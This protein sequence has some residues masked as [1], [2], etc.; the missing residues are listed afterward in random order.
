VD[1]GGGPVL[2][3]VGS[4]NATTREQL[5]RLGGVP[6]VAM[7]LAVEDVSAD[8]I[9]ALITHG[10][11]V[12]HPAAGEGDPQTIVDALAETAARAAAHAAGL[13]LTGGDT[14]VHVARRLGATG[15]LVEDELE[16]GVVIGRLLGPQS[17]RVVTKAG[18]FGSP[19]ALRNAGAALAAGGRTRA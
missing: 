13:V 14:A 3:V 10:T 8:V 18:G 4:V 12:L 16:P 1:A 17:F 5:A 7:P 2:I 15:L 6:A 11:C 19:D 9:A